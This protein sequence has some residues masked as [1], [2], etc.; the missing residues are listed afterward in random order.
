MNH[1]TNDD[2]N[3]QT[4]SGPEST[5][6]SL[7]LDAITERR[8]RNHLTASAERVT[9]SD[10]EPSSVRRTAR[11]R[12]VRRHRTLVGGVAAA[13]VMGMVVGVQALS[14]GGGEG[15]RF[16]EGDATA[17]ESNTPATPAVAPSAT[18]S[19]STFEASPAQLG[20]P[21][22]VWKVVEAEQS[23][24]I[25]G[26]FNGGGNQSFPGL[27]VSTSPGRS[28]DYD[29]VTPSVWRT[30][31]GVTWEQ[32]DLGLP[33]ASNGLWGSVASEGRL[34]AV[35]TAPGIAATDPNPLQVAVVG[36]DSTEWTVT[37][38]PFDT[39]AMTDLPFIVNGVQQS[40]APVADGVMI[41]VTPIA[42]VN[43]EALDKASDAFD[44]D[45]YWE[46]GPDGITVRADGCGVD[47]Y[48]SPSIVVMSATGAPI[49]TQPP[50]GT[51]APET[52]TD[53]TSPANDAAACAL[54]ELSWDNLGMPAESVAALSGSA[55]TFYLVGPDGTFSTT[56]SPVPGEQFASI[57]GGSSANFIITDS[58]GSWSPGGSTYRFSDGA[59]QTLPAP[60]V[61]WSTRPLRLGDANVGFG[62][63]PSE[64]ASQATFARVADDGST[65]FVDTD[66]LFGDYS[67]VSPSGAAI[68]GGKWVSAVSSMVDRLAEVGGAE[69][70]SDGL[71]VR[72]TSLSSPPVFIDVATGAEIPETDLVYGDDNTVTARNAAGDV[73][74]TV[75]WDDINDLQQR[76]APAEGEADW[77]IL[78]TADGT[79]FARE[80]VAELLG[81][82]SSAINYVPRV[83]SDG[84][85]VIVTVTLNERYPDDSLKQVSLVGTPIG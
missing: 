84:T 40:V 66:S 38:L 9:L 81:V 85:Q 37:D 18:P 68:A 26:T 55:T 13:T 24:S 71:I 1:S 67:M 50:T 52:A 3:N 72:T 59:W 32:T 2:T 51:Q 56:E 27:A 46:I 70:A 19:G 12:T 69:L 62:D 48:A 44:L 14:G 11:Q 53:T 20:E 33:F 34:F 83:Y 74:G 8:L 10:L 77:S 54:V 42:S 82:E 76:Y 61:N 58:F 65:S 16:T 23:N 35:G 22:F 28:N 6:T 49:T 45:Q 25:V 47:D 4:F 30:N 36:V 75:S 73:I 78:T 43:V 15:I 5:E 57:D 39:N 29:N 60:S 63:P 31:D 64:F 17:T 21:A 7:S 79:T 80:S 41:T